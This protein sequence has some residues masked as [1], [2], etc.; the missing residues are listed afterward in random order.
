M[1]MTIA[2]VSAFAVSRLV[3]V[4]LQGLWAVLTAVVVTE[5]TVGESLRATAEYVIGTLGGAVYASVI[6]VLVPHTTPLALAGLLVLAVAPMALAATLR[7]S[8][9]VAP[10]TAVIV[11]LISNQLG[12][13]PVEAAL[14][15]LLEVAIGG[16]TAVV[17]SLLVF[18]ERTHGQSVD[19]AAGVLDQLARAL[20]ELLTG[21]TR[22]IDAAKIQRIQDEIGR[23]VGSFESA[24]AEAE[25]AR[26]AHLLAPP[27]PGPL[28][29]TLLRLRHD[30]IMIGRTADAPLPDPVLA[31]L[32]TPLAR[33]GEG[34][35]DYLRGSAAAL[36]SRRAPPSLGPFE[37]ALESYESA[38]TAMRHES[39][40]RTLSGT[41]IERSFALG[42][43]LEQ[44]RRNFADLERCVSEY[45]HAPGR[46]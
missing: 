5:I 39:V 8:L 22:N 11:L 25:R 28:S 14:Y 24:A 33:V 10:F 13:G 32:C 15:R 20:P 34:A 12:E 17:V 38:V 4:P 36:G 46:A 9:R 1:R 29:R 26:L 40:T 44:L 41:E 19:S 7:P 45:A 35:S 43:A 27:D 23:T 42:F 21:F 18:P 31:L 3:N 16:A 6:G 30:L 37:A 2:A